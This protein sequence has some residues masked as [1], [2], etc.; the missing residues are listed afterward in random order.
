M[1]TWQFQTQ[2]NADRTV[3]LPPDVAAHLGANEP[4]HVVLI[5]GDPE[6]SDWRRLTAEQFL[7]GY[8]PGDEIYDRLPTG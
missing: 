3:N 4:V 5:T 2:V 1:A 8:G 7:A 6:E